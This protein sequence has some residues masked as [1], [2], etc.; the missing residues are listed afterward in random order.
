MITSYFASKKR[1]AEADTKPSS[2]SPSTP[3]TTC[4]E[5]S[6]TS[7]TDSSSTTKKAKQHDDAVQEMLEHLNDSLED[8]VSSW[9][10]ALD[11]HFSSNRFGNLAKFVASQR[12]VVCA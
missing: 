3:A 4:S 8:E 9:R 10:K 2:S 12:C 5:V 11:K 1:K 7:E 6:T